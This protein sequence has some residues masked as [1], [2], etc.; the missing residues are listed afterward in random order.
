MTI[1]DQAIAALN[2]L[3]DAAE[4]LEISASFEG[5]EEEAASIA[6]KAKELLRLTEDLIALGMKNWNE[7]SKEICADMLEANA[8]IQRE[9]KDIEKK[10]KVAEKVIKASKGL[11]KI[12]KK[13]TELLT[14]I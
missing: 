1:Q 7:N 10:V 9:I 4:N 3:S 14:K 8:E 11:D 12:I 6:E 13:A 2:E 5:M